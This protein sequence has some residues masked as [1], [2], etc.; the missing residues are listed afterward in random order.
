MTYN[1]KTK[2]TCSRSIELTIDD[3]GMIT[4]VQFLGGCNGNLQG[5]SS[6]VIGQKAEDISKKLKGINCNGKGTSC[7][8]QLSIAINEVLAKN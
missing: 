3:N 1:Y 4:D 2:G 5:I 6:L 8:D 7:P